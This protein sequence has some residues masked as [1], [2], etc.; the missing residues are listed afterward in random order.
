MSV[1]SF[2]PKFDLLQVTHATEA[3]Y[4]DQKWTLN[5]GQVTVFMGDDRFPMTKNFDRKKLD[6][7]ESPSEFLEIEQ[8]VDGFRLK[9][10]YRYIQKIEKTGTDTRSYRVKF[11]YRISLSFIPLIMAFLAVPFSV[12][13]RRSGGVAR[14]LGIGFGITIFYW[15][16]YSVGLSMGKS[17]ALTPWLGAWLPTF[18]FGLAGGILFWRKL[19]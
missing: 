17:G 1:Y 19:R 2:D 14:E 11:H 7:Q 18:I 16:F 13:M 9:E 4:R 8:E 10:L 3:H 5:D 15:L 12:G 6:I